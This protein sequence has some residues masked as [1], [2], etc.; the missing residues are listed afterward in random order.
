MEIYN[1]F[2]KQY[3]KFMAQFYS[4]EPRVMTSSSYWGNYWTQE[5]KHNI[6]FTDEPMLR[7]GI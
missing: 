4:T 5:L 2:E 6:L 7:K 1:C 3:T